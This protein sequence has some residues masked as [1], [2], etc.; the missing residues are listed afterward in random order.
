VECR[1]VPVSSLDIVRGPAVAFTDQGAVTFA[2]VAF[3]GVVGEI[4]SLQVQCRWERCNGEQVLKFTNALDVSVQNVPCASGEETL[5]AEDSK[6]MCRICSPGT[7][8]FDVASTQ[9]TTCPDDATCDGG[10]HIAADEGFW[11]PQGERDN[12]YECPFGE[13][14]CLG[15]MNSSCAKGYKSRLCGICEHNYLAS[16]SGCI[17][18]ASTEIWSP[19]I[20]LL[21]IGILIGLLVWAFTKLSEMLEKPEEDVDNETDMKKNIN[22]D[23]TATQQVA[24]DDLGKGDT[25]SNLGK[26]SGIGTDALEQLSVIGA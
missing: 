4:Y 16:A 21:I 9:C 10:N 2:S 18:C 3:S 15:G 26:G 14:G 5:I 1:L 11:S 22:P 6:V 8:S 19:M 13:D 17:S 25:S 24:L 12:I 23:E 20:T 7:Y